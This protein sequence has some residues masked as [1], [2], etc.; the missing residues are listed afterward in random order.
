MVEQIKFDREPQQELEPVAVVV[1]AKPLGDVRQQAKDTIDQMGLGDQWYAVDYVL[2]H[3]S[4]WRPDAV[5]PTGCIGLGQ[6]CPGG[7][8]L[9][10]ECPDWKTNVSCQVRHFTKYAQNRYGGWTGA[11]NFWQSNRW[12]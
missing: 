7:S 5:N 8:G 11:Y 3:E 10:A 12:W 9:S 4:T 6:S 1:A 2:S